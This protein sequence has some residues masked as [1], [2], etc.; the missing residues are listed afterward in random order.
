MARDRAVSAGPIHLS[1]RSVQ[2]VVVE[3]EDENRFMM[4]AKEAARACE[5]AQN[6]KDLREHFTQFLVYLMGWCNKHETEVHACYVYPG[7]G[8]L[9]VLVCTRGEEYRFDFDDAVTE[10]D[11]DLTR[12]FDWLTAEVMQVPEGAREG[13]VS[14]EKAILVYGDGS[15]PRAAGN[16]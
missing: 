12:Q 14:L 9:N 6:E 4:T 11:I 5:Q 2:Q 10:L 8:F 1:V 15:G 3:P 16:P 7:D 13:H